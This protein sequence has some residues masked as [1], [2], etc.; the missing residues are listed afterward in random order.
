MELTSMS[1]FNEEKKAI[2]QRRATKFWN[3]Q[4]KSILKAEI[5]Q[6]E[7]TRKMEVKI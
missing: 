3:N 1:R 4:T 7:E 6:I 5:N 2:G